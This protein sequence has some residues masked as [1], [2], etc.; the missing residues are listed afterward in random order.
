MTDIHDRLKELVSMHGIDILLHKSLVSIM[1]DEMIFKSYDNHPYCSLFSKA[2][3]LN[4]NEDICACT[5]WTA[6][7]AEDFAKR[8]HGQMSQAE[9]RYIVDCFSFAA[10]L[11]SAISQVSENGGQITQHVGL[12]D[13]VVPYIAHG[14]SK[15]IGTMIPSAMATPVHQQLNELAEEEESVA[16]FVLREMQ[17]NSQEEL[18]AKISGEQIDG[19]ALAIKQMSVGRGFII[20]D[21]TGVGKGRQLAMLVKW[22]TI[23]GSKPVVVTEKANL[24]NDLYRD[25]CDVGYGD[26]RPFILN[27]SNEAKIVDKDGFTAYGL[28]S[29]DDLEDFKILKQIPSG[30]DFL[31]L[32]YSQLNRDSSVNW[33]CKAVM[34]CI[35]N[36]YLIMDECHNASG[37]NSNIGKFFREA[38]KEATG[39]C[40]SSATFAKNPSS[41][42]IYAL[43]TAL[44]ESHIDSDD[45]I[46]IISRGGPILQEVMAKGLVDSGSMIRRQRDMK[47][48]E[49]DIYVPLN[50]TRMATV[51]DQYDTVVRLI[52]DINGYFKDYIKPLLRYKNAYDM[53]VAKYPSLK[54]ANFDVTRLPKIITNSFSVTMSPVIRKLLFAIKAQDAIDLT[55]A[56]LKAGRKPI[57]QISKTMETSLS[58]MGT[59]GTEL[60]SSNFLLTLI[61]SFEKIFDFKAVGYVKTGTGKKITI[62]KYEVP[63]TL[64]FDEL[65]LFYGNDDA[66]LA[67]NALVN[68]IKNTTINLTLSPIDWFIQNVSAQGY[69]VGEMTQR[70]L[71]F[72]YEDISKGADGKGRIERMRRTDKRELANQFNN[73][74][75]DVLIGNST[76]ASG[77]SLHSSEEFADTRQ[78]VVITWE[79]Q[80]RVDV[81]TQFDGRADRTGQVSH[82]AFR[83]LS[84]AIP[85]EQRYLMMNSSKQRS[86][87][88]NVQANQ[89]VETPCTDILNIYGAQVVH[90]YMKDHPEKTYLFESAL[91]IPLQQPE[92]K[93]KFIGEFMRSLCLVEC[94]EQEMIMSEI[95]S[96]YESLI[97]DLD[98]T[99]EN[100]LH[101][102][103]VP[104]NAT[105]LNRSVF[106]KGINNGSSAFSNNADL[107]EVEIDILRKPF[108]SGEL[109]V[110][111][112]ELMTPE[113]LTSKIKTAVSQRVNSITQYYENLRKKAQD[114]LNEITLTGQKI[115]PSRKALLEERVNNSDKLAEQIKKILE[116]NDL[117]LQIVEKFQQFQPVAIPI[118]FREE[119]VLENPSLTRNVPIGMFLGYRLVGKEM[120]PSCIKAVF[121]VND[122]RRQIELPLSHCYPFELILKQTHVG[123]VWNQIKTLT[124]D[125]WDNFISHKRREHAYIVTGNLILGIAKANKMGENIRNPKIAEYVSSM[126]K[127]K[128][129][130]YTD[131]RGQ[132]RHGYLLPRYYS[133]NYLKTVLNYN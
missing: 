49:R 40:F 110:K 97:T 85:A 131:N 58:R 53:L 115:I 51:R 89:K 71:K 17:L 70:K 121:A 128:L 118:A 72:E 52:Y 73:G 25:L 66:E 86:L 130:A 45:L 84:S 56:E 91:K 119:A 1:A 57:V 21:M 75:I 31:L 105:L 16:D 103:V 5:D 65:K 92:G 34:E 122:S 18:E 39:V 62:K 11:I 113:T 46:R 114:Q 19:V 23:Q 99:G 95:L 13:E 90:E 48:V 29:N 101:F 112:S 32:T 50:S 43:K 14:S 78:R 87:N 59:V 74:K 9:A 88:A 6:D 33:K 79:M 133:P 7:E 120:V 35:R 104:L 63:S 37:S 129:I 27:S 67:Y 81:Q 82:C 47:D 109:T 107:D 55:L 24:F 26:L 4:L 38:V 108:V 22:A 98:A 76:M 20:G 127:G 42:P 3:K 69:S 126:C 60:D 61:D 10:G 106:A 96:R 125:T 12:A 100:E 80:E 93:L 36:S 2:V 83:I 124:V 8:L 111:A 28:P 30:Y 68:K 102:N 64:G 44:G 116:S 123:A 132:M 15:C 94:D 77:I 54:K 117:L 41:M